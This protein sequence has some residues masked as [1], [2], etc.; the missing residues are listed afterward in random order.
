MYE[1]ELKV[2]AVLE[3]VRRQLEVEGAT[4]QGTV[5]QEDT[6]YDA[7]HRSFSETDEAL[8]I[9]R[10]LTDETAESRVTYKGP[11]L[12]NESKTRAEHETGVEDGE[13][14]DDVLCALGFEP[15]ATVYKERERYALEGYTV[16]L[17][18]VDDVGEYVEIEAETESMEEIESVRMGAKRVLERLDLDPETQ[19]RTSY[20][21]LLLE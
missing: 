16:T 19:L 12:D 17:D 18:A 3:T 20:L 10:E 1:V 9:R 8:R 5:T 21:E 6:Y 15:V 14:M 2:E 11:L 4:K 7:P 13:T